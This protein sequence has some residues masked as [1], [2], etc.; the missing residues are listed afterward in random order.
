MTACS[1]IYITSGPRLTTNKKR[2]L[3]LLRNEAEFGRRSHNDEYVKDIQGHDE[4]R[5]KPRTCLNDLPYLRGNSLDLGGPEKQ[6]QGKIKFTDFFMY[7]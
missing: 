3:W 7:D 2:F 1:L 5:A 4:I 6:K